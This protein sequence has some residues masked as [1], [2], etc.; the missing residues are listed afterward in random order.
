M[1]F[2]GGVDSTLVLRVAGDVLGS[3]VLAVTGRSPSVPAHELEEAKALASSFGVR[4]QIVD[5]FEL[6]D[7]RYVANAPD[8]C[9]FCKAELFEKLRAVREAEGLAVIVDGTNADDLS[10]HRPGLRA[11]AER[12]IVSPL[13]EL[14]FAKADVR[15]LSRHLGLPTSEKPALACLASRIPYGTKVTIESLARIEAAEVKVRE[16]GFRQFRVRHHGELARV[17]IE[18]S[19]LIRALQPETR[20]ALVA[21]LKEAG[22]RWVALDLEGY[23]SGSLNEALRKGEPAG[24]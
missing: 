20:R 18:P 14:G 16:L 1:A 2:S 7:P 11:R 4:H 23:R 22:Y 19:E 24:R 17:E 5:T 15:M 21:G 8:R 3:R 13:A 10:D 6:S 9:Y 12:G